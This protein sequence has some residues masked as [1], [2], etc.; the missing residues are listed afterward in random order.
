MH[1]LITISLCL[2]MITGCGTTRRVVETPSRVFNIVTGGDPVL[3]KSAQGVFHA[4]TT[5]KEEYC[6]G[7]G[8]F[9]GIATIGM[10]DASIHPQYGEILQ[11]IFRHGVII[12]NH[13]SVSYFDQAGHLSKLSDLEGE[14]YDA[15]IDEL[16]NC[17][18]NSKYPFVLKMCWEKLLK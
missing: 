13:C 11:D 2:L 15:Y 8:M 5:K 7:Y 17:A 3:S 1:K 9:A 4:Q 18:Y 12:E 10:Y 16:N 14:V 6:A